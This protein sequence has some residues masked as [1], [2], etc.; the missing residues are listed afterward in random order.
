MK[1]KELTS[2]VTSCKNAKAKSSKT[3][4]KAAQVEKRERGRK[5]ERRRE[6]VE[7]I[8]HGKTVQR[9]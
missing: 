6:V 8:L 2:N 3:S 9:K 5:R 7:R 1:K 4:E